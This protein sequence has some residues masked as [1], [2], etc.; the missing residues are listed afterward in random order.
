LGVGGWAPP[1]PPPP[2]T[3]TGVTFLDEHLTLLA[4]VGHAVDIMRAY[5]GVRTDDHLYVHTTMMY[6]CCYTQVTARREGVVA[7]ACFSARRPP[8]AAG[9]GAGL[10]A[11]AGSPRLRGLR[12]P[13]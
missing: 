10:A 12:L 7:V 11:L 5:P 1:P 13:L 3:H 2:H 8:K 4:N 9:G 6:L